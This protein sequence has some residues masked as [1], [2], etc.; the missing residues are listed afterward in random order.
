MGN[1]WFGDRSSVS[2]DPQPVPGKAVDTPLDEPV[3]VVQVVSPQVEMMDEQQDRVDTRMDDVETVP[4]QTLAC[5][6]DQGNESIAEEEI[7]AKEIQVE[8][9]EVVEQ[10]NVDP[11]LVLPAPSQDIQTALEDQ[12]VVESESVVMDHEEENLTTES[13]DVALQ[14]D[15]VIPSEEE[16]D[17]TPV[18][19][20]MAPSEPDER[21]ESSPV[22]SETILQ[23]FVNTGKEALT[24]LETVESQEQENRDVSNL[25]QESHIKVSI[26]ED[27]SFASFLE[28]MEV[29][30]GGTIRRKK[31]QRRKNKA[32]RHR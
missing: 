15:D 30:K 2:S 27:Q 24:E 9:E 21:M 23:P 6:F 14:Q 18:I 22:I 3:D 32:N 16:T 19:D 4:V 17:L 31:G 8:V 25:S 11:N 1:C 29:P 20:T 5:D 26:S 28:G 13:P 10:A 12:K 7:H